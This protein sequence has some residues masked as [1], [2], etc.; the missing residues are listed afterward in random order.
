MRE[1]LIDLLKVFH[2]IPADN[3]CHHDEQ[4]EDNNCKE[5]HNHQ[6]NLVRIEHSKSFITLLAFWKW[7]HFSPVIISE[8]LNWLPLLSSEHSFRKISSP[9]PSPSQ[10]SA[11]SDMRD[12]TLVWKDLVITIVVIP[13]PL[14]DSVSPLR[15][16]AAN[17]MKVCI[18]CDECKICADS[19]SKLVLFFHHSEISQTKSF[20]HF[21]RNLK[22]KT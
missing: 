9:L 3:D 20:Y 18:T 13:N 4:V 10:H 11:S 6:Q 16:P 12:Q 2:D 14:L 15:L 7:L 8:F 19:Q 1:D 21:L 5:Y 22:I 17:Q